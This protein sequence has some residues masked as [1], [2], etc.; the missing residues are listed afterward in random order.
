MGTMSDFLMRTMEE[1]SG[2]WASQS[3]ELSGSH[4]V[5]ITS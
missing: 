5:L 3:A 2:F 1:M 4:G